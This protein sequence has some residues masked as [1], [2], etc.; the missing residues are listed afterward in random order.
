[1]NNVNVEQLI[2]SRQN[3]FVETRTIIEAEINKF[4]QSLEKLDPDI[5]TRCNVIP[6][7]TA[8]SLVPSL[9]EEPFDKDKYAVELAAVDSYIERVK[10]VCDQI[11]KEALE[12]LQST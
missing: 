10:T 1:M 5:Q 8:K 9:W 12:C 6:G 11:N 4:L 7:Q 3:K 2:Q